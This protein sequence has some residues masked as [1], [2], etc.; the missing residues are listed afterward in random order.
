MLRIANY[1]NS[2]NARSKKNEAINEYKKIN[3]QKIANKI[4]L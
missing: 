3:R 2:H 1:Q 4:S